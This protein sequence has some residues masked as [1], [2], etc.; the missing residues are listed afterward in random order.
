LLID[1]IDG[2]PATRVTG[3]FERRVRR[4]LDAYLSP[5]EPVVVAA[6]GGPDSTAILIAVAR[7]R[8]VEAPVIA[9]CFD[10]RLR[11][12]TETGQ[13]RA[14]IEQLTTQ[15]GVRFVAG[16]ARSRPGGEQ[17]PEAAARVARYGWLARAC[18]EAGAGWCIT[19]HTLDDQ[20]ETVLLRLVRGATLAGA[21]G[22]AEVSAWPVPLLRPGR[23]GAQSLLR[24]LLS[25]RRSEGGRYLAALGV[26]AR[27]DPSNDS[28]DF[29]RNRVR[30]RVLPELRALNPRVEESFARFADQARLDDA[31]L[32]QRA[33]W[34]LTLARMPIETAGPIE[35]AERV[36]LDRRHLGALPASIA[37]R[38]VRQAAAELC[39]AIDAAQ[40]RQVLRLLERAGRTQIRGGW[41]VVQ[42]EF[43]EIILN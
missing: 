38:V 13:D 35:T 3:A 6:S 26:Q 36:R 27:R 9:A 28:L 22:M 21:A 30:Q 37:V 42:G 40:A 5:E 1:P 15:L 10:H 39:L 4:V 29:D 41:I 16:R 24:P 31:A 14:F 11:P 33:A 25:T 23:A 2:L 32:A 7:L 43:L 18:R 20:A 12:R 19:G 8:R 34:E 17:G